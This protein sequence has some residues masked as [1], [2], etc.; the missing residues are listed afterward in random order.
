MRDS[1]IG[2]DAALLPN[3]FKVFVQGGRTPA[4]ES[5]YHGLG[6][7]LSLAQMLT[8]MHGGTVAAQSDGPGRGSEFTVR[9]PAARAM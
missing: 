4:C 2:I 8:E 3:V 6:L 5:A 9:L 1:G 7:G